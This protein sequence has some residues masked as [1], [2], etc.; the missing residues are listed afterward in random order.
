MIRIIV[1]LQIQPGRTVRPIRPL[2]AWDLNPGLELPLPPEIE[3][4]LIRE[5]FAVR[6]DERAIK[7]QS[8]D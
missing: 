8:W 7:A 6:I 4:I 2:L 5:G 1:P 3:E